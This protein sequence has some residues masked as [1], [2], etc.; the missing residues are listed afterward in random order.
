[1]A[2][3]GGAVFTPLMGWISQSSG[4]ATAYLVPCTAYV[5][6]AYYGFF[7]SRVRSAF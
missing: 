1:M 2:I 6:V 7:G 4:L 5:F 3:I